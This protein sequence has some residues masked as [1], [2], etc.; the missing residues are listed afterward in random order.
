MARIITAAKDRGRKVMFIVIYLAPGDYHRYHSPTSF[1]ANYRRHL[2]GYLEPVDPR[3][4]KKHRDVLKNNERVNLFGDWQFGFFAVS[5][6]GATNVGSIK[7][8]FD[9]VLK[10]NVANPDYPFINDR[11]YA[12]L[13]SADNAFMA[14]P[15]RTGT[16]AN[17][18][19]EE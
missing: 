11:N 9:D 3:Y 8:H 1:T 6:V 17:P 12:T 16:D 14:F 10:T 19:A 2:P 18:Y 7:I 5:F 13:S 15:A 4:L